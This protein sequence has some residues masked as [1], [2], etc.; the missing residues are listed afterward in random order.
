M[1]FTWSGDEHVTLTCYLHTAVCWDNITRDIDL[2]AEEGRKSRCFHSPNIHW[3]IHYSA[4]VSESFLCCENTPICCCLRRL[5]SA[6]TLRTRGQNNADQL[7]QGGIWGNASIQSKSGSTQL[8]ISKQQ[9]NKNN[10]KT[11][12]WLPFSWFHS[13]GAPCQLHQQFVTM[14]IGI[15]FREWYTQVIDGLLEDNSQYRRS[16]SSWESRTFIQS[17]G[18]S[19]KMFD[20]KLPVMQLDSL[21]PP[22][23]QFVTTAFD[24]TSVLNRHSHVKS[25]ECL[26]KLQYRQ[27]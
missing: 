15:T 17:N 16:S 11:Q 10:K 19:S 5:L 2:F 22:R 27:S 13:V 3:I 23:L 9:N 12:L 8:T 18:E 21:F 20:P 7:K 24:S 4:A 26:F 25:V 14:R 1:I 6:S